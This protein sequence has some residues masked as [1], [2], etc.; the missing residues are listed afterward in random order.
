MPKFVIAREVQENLLI[1]WGVAAT[2][3]CGVA[4]FAFVTMM[5]LLGEYIPLTQVVILY[6]PPSLE[7]VMAP[8]TPP[9]TPEPQPQ[10][11]KRQTKAKPKPS[12]PRPTGINYRMVEPT[13][14]T[15]RNQPPPS[16]TV[17]PDVDAFG[18]PKLKASREDA[19][20]PK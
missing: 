15:P 14:I 13:V 18:V 17:I 7:S 12:V 20:R 2:A 6:E 4:M 16:G 8:A 11:A 19:L 5:M 9:P 1:I 10:V 3:L